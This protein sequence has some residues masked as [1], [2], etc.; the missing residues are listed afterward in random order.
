MQVLESSI[1]RRVVR[2]A[3]KLGVYALKLAAT[4]DT[5]WPDRLFLMPNG[6]TLFIEFKRPG[7]LPRPKQRYIH[8]LLVKLGHNVAVMDDFEE[9][10]SLIRLILEKANAKVDTA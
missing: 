6:A 1:E 9:S 5:G 3:E 4:G 10:M 7:Y 2:E 8:A